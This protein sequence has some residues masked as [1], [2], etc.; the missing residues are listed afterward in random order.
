MTDDSAGESEPSGRND[1]GPYQRF[2]LGFENVDRI[3]IFGLCF[4]LLLAVAVFFH[5]G[6]IT[7]SPNLLDIATRI[8]YL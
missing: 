6:I 3:A 8:D 1:G 5:L 7:L 4:I 2:T